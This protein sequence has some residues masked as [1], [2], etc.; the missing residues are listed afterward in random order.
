[1]QRYRSTFENQY[2]EVV[3]WVLLQQHSGPFILKFI[4]DICCSAPNSPPLMAGSNSCRRRVWGNSILIIPEIVIIGDNILSSR[5]FSFPE[6]THAALTN[7]IFRALIE[8][9]GFSKLVHCILQQVTFLA[10]SSSS[11]F[12][13][14]TEMPQLVVLELRSCQGLSCFRSRGLSLERL[15]YFGLERLYH[16]QNLSRCPYQYNVLRNSKS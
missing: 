14:F 2:I 16:V 3:N 11:S 15:V 12:N 5:I 1:M 4:L 7:C 9:K 10:S 13:G 6:L 8:V